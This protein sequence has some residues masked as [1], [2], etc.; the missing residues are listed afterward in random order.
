MVIFPQVKFDGQNII[1]IVKW[2]LFVRYKRAK[3]TQDESGV[4]EAEKRIVLHR[5]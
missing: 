2:L 4:K 5:V 3:S 1:H